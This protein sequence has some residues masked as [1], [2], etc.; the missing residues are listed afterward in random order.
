MEKDISIMIGDVR[1]NFRVG[2]ILE[3]N[4]KV[5]IEKSKK[6]DFGVIPGGRIK[7]QEDIK[8]ALIREINEEMHYDISKKEIVLQHI[9][10]NFFNMDNIK[11][12]ELYFVYR[13]KLDGMDDIVNRNDK[14]FI[15]YDS[16]SGW[17]EF[18]DIKNI[19]KENIKP[20]EL[21]RIIKE[22]EFGTTIV[23]DI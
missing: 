9:I 13:V 14:E 11:Y 8:S 20:N 7:T 19:E 2:V 16:E 10:E 4:G 21:K 6:V 5:I 12:H 23:R 1:F 18:V 15:N 3:Y 17:Y 22:K